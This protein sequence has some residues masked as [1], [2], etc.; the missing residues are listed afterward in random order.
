[1]AFSYTTSKTKREHKNKNKNLNIMTQ[2][3]TQI[4]HS[5]E[6][7]IVQKILL[8]VTISKILICL[9][10]VNCLM[11]GEVQFIVDHCCWNFDKNPNNFK[12]NIVIAHFPHN[13]LSF[14]QNN[15]KLKNSPLLFKL[16]VCLLHFWVF[17]QKIVWPPRKGQDYLLQIC[18]LLQF[19]E[20]MNLLQFLSFY[21]S[22]FLSFYL[23]HSK[24]GSK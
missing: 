12:Q 14:K 8:R 13:I 18:I 20:F 23:R 6:R 10:I 19:L 24:S 16:S 22:I 3:H 21:L 17:T 1:M 5:R 11:V 7:N 4:M 15:F 2:G 9:Q